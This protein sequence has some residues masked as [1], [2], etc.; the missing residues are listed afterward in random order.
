MLKL[1]VETLRFD[2]KLKRFQFICGYQTLLGI[3]L[4]FQMLW[5]LLSLKTKNAEFCSAGGLNLQNNPENLKIGP[6]WTVLRRFYRVKI[7]FL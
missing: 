3:S 4:L 6:I 5:P 2:P 7:S 1:R